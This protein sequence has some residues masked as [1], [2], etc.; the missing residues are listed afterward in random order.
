MYRVGDK[1]KVKDAPWLK[2]EFKKKVG[3]IELV[4]QANDTKQ[5]CR[6]SFGSSIFDYEDLSSLRLE[7][8]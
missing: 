8:V 4:V 7:L 5:Y 3:T 1:V 6:V 2:E